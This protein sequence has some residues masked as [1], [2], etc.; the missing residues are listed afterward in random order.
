MSR[1]TI[2]YVTD[3]QGIRID[4]GRA[5]EQTSLLTPEEQNQLCNLILQCHWVEQGTRPDLAYEA[6][7]L[8]SKFDKAVVSDLIRANKNLLKLKQLKSF[9]KFPNLG[10]SK[11][12]KIVVFSDASHANM[13]SV[14]C[15]VCED[16][17][18]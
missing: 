6:V 7:E 3:L 4:P 14:V 16:I 15:Q 12:W 1:H 2:K 18:F 10:H 8:S 9:I 5:K 13:D 17:L 11:D